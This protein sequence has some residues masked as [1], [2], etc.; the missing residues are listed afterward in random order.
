MCEYKHP[1]VCKIYQLAGDTKAVKTVAAK[2]SIQPFVEN[3]KWEDGL[4]HVDIRTAKNFIPQSLK[5][6][7][8][9]TRR[10]PKKL[11]LLHLVR[12]QLLPHGANMHGKRACSHSLLLHRIRLTLR[13]GSKT[14]K[15]T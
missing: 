3:G 6:S 8:L 4:A 1:G 13:K 10:G 11:V 5:I 14:C 7:P 2:N 15:K 12:G 9:S